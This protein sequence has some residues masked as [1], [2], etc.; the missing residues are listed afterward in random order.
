MLEGDARAVATA[1]LNAI[2]HACSRFRS[3]SE[4][5]PRQ[6]RS[7]QTRC[8]RPVAARSAERRP[9]C[10]TQERRARRPYRWG[11][12]CARWATTRR[13]AWWRCATATPFM[14]PSRPFPDGSASSSIAD[15]ATVRI[16]ARRG[17]RPGRNRKGPRLR[18]HR[19]CGCGRRRRHAREPRRRCRRRRQ[20]PRA[21]GP[22]ASPTITLRRSTRPGRRSR[23]RAAASRRRRRPRADGAAGLSSFITSSIRAPDALRTHVGGRSPSQRR[24]A[25]TRTSRARPPSCLLTRPRG[26]R[27][28]VFLRALCASTATARSSRAGPRTHRER[29]RAVV[30]DAWHRCRPLLLLTAWSSRSVSQARR[31]GR[32]RAGRAS[33]SPDSIA[34]SRPARAR[35]HRDPRDHDGR[36]RL[37]ADL[38]AQRRASVHVCLSTRL[39]RARRRRARPP[40]RPDRHEPAAPPHRL[41]PL[42]RAA[43][44]RLCVVADRA[45]ARPRHGHGRASRLDAGRHRRCVAC[46]VAAVLW[47]IASQRRRTE[48]AP[49]RGRRVRAPAR[50]RRA[51]IVRRPRAARLG[52]PARARRSRCCRT[53]FGRRACSPPSRRRRPTLRSAPFAARSAAASASRGRIKN[54]R[55]LVD[56]SGRTHGA[57]AGRAVDPP[58]GRAERG[59]RRRD[60]G[61]RRVLRAGATFPNAYV[62]K[63]VG[64]QGNADPALARRTGPA[65]SPC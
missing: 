45:H 16:P 44:A 41:P 52:L 13:S 25:L 21:G 12:R 30:R 46:V 47:R 3:D 28:V 63:I 5:S 7:W 10:R 24:P 40:A 15:S 11:R 58:A 65:A 6:S 29:T 54:G 61:E 23:C 22:C 1:E 26:W 14:R 34:T 62:G 51:G 9:R 50:D 20:R 55:V 36:R 32:A 39:A 33:S 35:L 18:S 8:R 57:R 43:L 60:D 56:I 4:L 59:R 49:R 19:R 48:S 31:A 27:S 37:R 2:D 64:L 42:A 38:P 17:A 53:P